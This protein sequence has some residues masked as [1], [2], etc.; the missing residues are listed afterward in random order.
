M[1]DMNGTETE[2]PAGAYWCVVANVVELR[3]FGPGGIEKRSGTKL[4]KAKSKVYIIDWY[5]GM[6]ER[7]TVIAR[8]R[9]SLNFITVT[10]DVK[11]LENFR[12][13]QILHPVV[14]QHYK[15][16]GCNILSRYQVEF[17]CEVLPSWT[18]M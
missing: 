6:C 1:I 5:G 13:R 8:H 2:L 12:V 4:F 10:M 7:V 3:A 18:L 16:S 15:Q 14:L 9:K 17:M 11:C